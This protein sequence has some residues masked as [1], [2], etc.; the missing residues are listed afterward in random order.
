MFISLLCNCNCALQLFC[1]IRVSDTWI[2]CPNIR[3]I[4]R[5]SLPCSLCLSLSLFLSLSLSYT[6]SEL[7]LIFQSDVSNR[8][9]TS[10]DAAVVVEPTSNDQ[11]K[12]FDM[13]GWVEFVALSSTYDSQLSQHT[14]RVPLEARA[15][16]SVVA[17]DTS[18]LHFDNCVFGEMYA[19]Y[20]TITNRSE[21]AT[22]CSLRFCDTHVH[23]GAF[24][25][26]DAES[27]QPIHEGQWFGLLKPLTNTCITRKIWTGV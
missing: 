21:L 23:L 6:H 9:A 18:E 8:A 5:P 13:R 15:C 7:L 25:L 4:D 24:A 19:R 17:L 2:F 3:R 11:N 26:S 1:R 22:R 10:E 27:S 14:I 16:R 20:I 12:L